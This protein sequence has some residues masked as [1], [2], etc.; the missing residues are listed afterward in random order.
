M[1]NATT[2][3]NPY[4]NS[5]HALECIWRLTR[6]M[7]KAGWTTMATS[8]G[9]LKVAPATNGTDQWG[10]NA[11]PLTDTFPG[12]ANSAAWI[13]MRGPSTQKIS[14]AVPPTGQPVRGEKIIQGS[15]EGELLGYVFDT[16]SASGW[17]VI[18]PRVGNFDASTTITCASSGAS[19]SLPPAGS[20]TVSTFVREV[21]FSKTSALADNATG[22]LFYI[23]A[24]LAAENAQLYSSIAAAAATATV[25][26]GCGTAGNAFPALGIS[27]RG[28]GG[29]MSGG[30]PWFGLSSG[31]IGN[32]HTGCVNNISAPG[33]SSDGSFYLTG[34]STG[35]NV[36]LLGF[37]FMRLDDTD[38]GDCDPYVFLGNFNSQMTT[39]N[40][41]ISTSYGSAPSALSFGNF[42]GGSYPGFAGY[43]ARG[44][45]IVARDVV[46]PYQGAATYSSNYTSV[47]NYPQP[48]R[49]LN[50]P[51]TNPPLTRE[52][53]LLFC[54]GTTTNYTTIKHFKGRVRWISV[55]SQGSILDTFDG[56]KYICTNSFSSS[57]GAIIVGPWDGNTTPGA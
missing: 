32:Y 34:S 52:N 42:Y 54:P 6:T 57:N 10:S 21:M 2:S 7:K 4:V 16:G 14:I 50:H 24:D 23:C 27:V 37:G 45:P 43:Q 38:P 51:A 12:F 40:R 46:A 5:T 19:F 55:V 56:K 35:S 25:A 44:C 33:I 49:T 29:S 28:T 15:A 36:Y 1:A 39:F 18:A 13:V 41:T 22:I 31:Y 53:I 47:I 17:I 48:I 26:P 30:G 20:T 8:N 3:N 11:D 9:T